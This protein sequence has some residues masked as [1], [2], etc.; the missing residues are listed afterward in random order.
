MA[1]YAEFHAPAVERRDE[2]AELVRTDVRRRAA[3]LQARPRLRRRDEAR[4]LPP[5]GSIR[6]LRNST[7]M[8]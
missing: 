2:R 6:K 5:A 3:G 8:P 1:V 4:Q 7:A